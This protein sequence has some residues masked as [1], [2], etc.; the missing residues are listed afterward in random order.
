MGGVKGIIVS[1]P[2]EWAG[3]TLLVYLAPFYSDEETG[4]GIFVL[5][6]G[7]HPHVEVEPTGAFQLDNVPPAK[8]VIVIGP[9]PE[10]ALAIPEGDHP[11]VFTIVEGEILDLGEIE[12]P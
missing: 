6:P 5:E 8:Y 3:S 10:K 11:R 9:G 12:L 2:P 4:E 7:A 1:T